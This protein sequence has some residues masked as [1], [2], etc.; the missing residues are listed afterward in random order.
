MS[1]SE[2]RSS[3]GSSLNIFQTEWRPKICLRTYPKIHI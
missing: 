2:V 1:V 3:R